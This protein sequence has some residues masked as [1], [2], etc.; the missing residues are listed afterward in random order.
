MLFR[1]NMEPQC[2]TCERA[3]SL[4]DGVMLCRKLGAVSESYSCKKYKYDPLKRK[5]AR[6]PPIPSGKTYTLE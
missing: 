2:I 6:T 4:G 1:K 3:V 5:P